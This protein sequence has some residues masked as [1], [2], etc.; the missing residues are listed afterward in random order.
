VRVQY[1]ENEAREE[2]SDMER[3]WALTQMKR[4]LGDAPW[5]AVE[6]QFGISRSR[7][8]ELTRMLAFTQAQQRQVALLRL[9]ETQI[10]G[11]HTAVRAGELSST[12]VDAILAR[13]EQIAAERA[14]AYAAT[15]SADAG[16]SA[17]PRQVRI[18]GPT[19]A[20]LVAHA[21]RS[22]GPAAAASAAPTPRWLPPLREQL[23]RTTQRVR[24]ASKRVGSLGPNDLEGLLADV[25]Q[26]AEELRN[27][28]TRTRS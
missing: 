1:A 22:G 12:Q 26:L 15:S 28:K 2:F 4:A 16:D 21:E 23:T 18:D 27:L 5:E 7:R 14:S 9:Q 17:A 10:R 13:L 6:S 24:R 25:D 20:R 11:L 8:H 19:I 3:A